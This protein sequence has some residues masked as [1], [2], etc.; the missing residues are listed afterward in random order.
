MTAQEFFTKAVQYLS[1]KKPMVIYRKPTREG[2][3]H[4][5]MEGF[6]QENDELYTTEDFSEKGF[7]FAPF[8][9][10]HKNV[11]IPLKKAEKITA[12]ITTKQSAGTNTKKLASDEKEKQTHL[13][14]VA[15][16]IEAIQHKKLKKVVLSHRLTTH[17]DK[18][19]MAIFNALLENY[20]TAFVY[21]WYHPK[22]GLWLGATPETLLATRGNRLK[23]MAVAGTK[24][25]QQTQRNTN[26]QK[27][28]QWAAKE[29]Y[30]QQLV[31]DAITEALN[32]RMKQFSVSKPQDYRA[33]NVWHLKTDFS[34][35]IDKSSAKVNP[36][37]EII[38]NLHPTPAVCGLPKHE[39]AQFI[40]EHEGYDR[41]F[42]TGFLG[43]LNL[44]EKA[45]RA[46]N[47]RN[48]ENQAYAVSNRVTNLF[49]NLRC[50]QLLGKKVHLYVGGGIT[51]ESSPE[52]EWEE[53][54]QKSQT[55]L[56]AL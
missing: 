5:L 43:E 1:K 38:D 46:A 8:Q 52:S 55:M 21:C 4:F 3:S 53:T 27:R 10:T 24:P 28:P 30:E 9:K 40:L 11:L 39:A 12:E 2:V 19:P 41:E 26:G 13:K 49:V 23:T 22:I 50:M 6:F 45:T 7:V 37:R 34:G 15:T 32:P 33:G 51:S 54:Q 29:R 35:I 31:T 48:Q 18:E 44:T 20:P 56:K 14:L 16:G 42:Y 17:T 47:R 25:V 36:W